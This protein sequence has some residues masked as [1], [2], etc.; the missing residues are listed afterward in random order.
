M[1]P[2]SPEG[3]KALKSQPPSLENI[4][5]HTHQIHGVTKRIAARRGGAFPADEVYRIIDG[6]S[7]L[8]PQGVRHMPVWGYEFFDAERR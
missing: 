3:L 4:C 2:L 7:E 1:M 8:L 5:T 6:Q